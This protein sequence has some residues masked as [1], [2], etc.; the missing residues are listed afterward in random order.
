MIELGNDSMTKSQIDWP[1][2]P[3]IV[4]QGA[5]EPKWTVQTL[6]ARGEGNP[7]CRCRLKPGNLHSLKLTAKAL[8]NWCFLKMICSFSN[9]PYFQAANC[10]FTAVSFQG[11]KKNTTFSITLNDGTPG[12][13]FFRNRHGWVPL[14]V[15]RCTKVPSEAWELR[16]KWEIAAWSLD[17]ITKGG[18]L[19]KNVGK[20]LQNG[21]LKNQAY[22]IHR[23]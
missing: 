10:D 19:G 18:E 21:S 8:N 12:E 15:V 23:K 13:F 7:N 14:P 1:R 20:T 3:V 5:F 17:G 2:V 16:K 6:L 9:M 11:G 4:E 22:N